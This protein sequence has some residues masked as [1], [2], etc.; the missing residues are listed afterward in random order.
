MEKAMCPAK[1]K[2]F[3]PSSK[4]VRL[5]KLKSAVCLTLLDLRATKGLLDAG[6]DDLP[7]H[8]GERG[9]DVALL[10]HQEGPLAEGHLAQKAG[11]KMPSQAPFE[12]HS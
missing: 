4:G 10:D 9:L 7:V 11:A 12:A 5:T 1:T 2:R 3:P 6:Q 8:L